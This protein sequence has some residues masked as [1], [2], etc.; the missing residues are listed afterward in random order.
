MPAA[1]GTHSH[2]IV[3]DG[4]L[5]FFVPHDGTSNDHELK[6]YVATSPTAAWTEH[7]ASPLYTVSGSAEWDSHAAGGAA[8]EHDGKLYR[9]VQDCRGWYGQCVRAFEVTELSETAFAETLV[10][11]TPLA[12]ATGL[13]ASAV[14]MHV[15]SHVQLPSGKWLRASDAWKTHCHEGIDGKRPPRCDAAV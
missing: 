11:E 4:L 3:R 15:V 5:Y 8:V 1:L 6:L 2:V 7:P 12:G 14:G 10:S 9:L 13:G